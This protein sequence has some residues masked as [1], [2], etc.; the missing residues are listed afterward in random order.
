[1]ICMKVRQL[2]AS[3]AQPES[4]AAPAPTRSEIVMK[5][6]WDRRVGALGA[7]DRR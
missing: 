7:T 5:R 6:E 4:D 2:S 1:M 3:R